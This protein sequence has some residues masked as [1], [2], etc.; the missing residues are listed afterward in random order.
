MNK[1]KQR[2]SINANAFLAYQHG[3][4]G[5]SKTEKGNEDSVSNVVSK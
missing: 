2:N 5:D 1:V 3:D 4:M